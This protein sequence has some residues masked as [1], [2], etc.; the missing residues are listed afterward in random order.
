MRE[1]LFALLI[2]AGV[3]FAQ[4]STSLSGSGVCVALEKAISLAGVVQYAGTS[5][6][7]LVG[8]AIAGA[9]A[10]RER[11]ATALVVGGFSVILAGLFFFIAPMLEKGLDAL[12]N[13]FC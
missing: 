11:I 5:F 3:V 8:L 12:K 7:A 13:S 6:I 4:T 1:T 2:V 10:W 9:M